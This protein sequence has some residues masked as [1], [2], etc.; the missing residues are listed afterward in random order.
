MS[1][2]VIGRRHDEQRA[3][4]GDVVAARER[5]RARA[6]SGRRG[7]GA[8]PSGQ[9]VGDVAAEPPPEPLR[10]LPLHP[11]DH[12][13]RLR[14]IRQ[15]ADVVD[16]EVREDDPADVVAACAAPL[17]RGR[18]CVRLDRLEA[19]ETEPGVPRKPARRAARAPGPASKRQSPAGWSIST[20]L[21]GS[22][23]SLQPPGRWRR[24][25][26]RCFPRTRPA[27]STSIAT[28][29]GYS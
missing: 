14:R 23:D 19:G 24:L 1:R 28:W 9:S 11:R 16:V 21:R 8:R 20:T 10:P 26:V 17:E 22:V 25:P 6:A 2:R 18:E 3:V 7:A 12:D 15:P 4:P 27:S 29:G 5:G 13:V